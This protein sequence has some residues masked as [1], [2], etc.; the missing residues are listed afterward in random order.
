MEIKKIE[1]KEC[2]TSYP[3]TLIPDGG[4]CVYC[5]ADEAEKVAAPVEK[6]A[7]SPK[8]P[9]FLEKRPL[10]ANSL[11]EPCPANMFSLLSK[12]LTPI[13]WRDGCIKIFV[14]GSKG[15]VKR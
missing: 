6:K 7:P 9:K 3:E 10:N 11:S 14:R 5:K 2:L 12:G 13:T 15:L 1:C 8:K 4:V